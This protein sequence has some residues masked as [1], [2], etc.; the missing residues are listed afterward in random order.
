MKL[1]REFT[2]AV[3]KGFK[4]TGNYYVGP[5]ALRLLDSGIRLITM[6]TDEPVEYDLKR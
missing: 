1:Y 5:E 4:K 6:G 3:T 2:R